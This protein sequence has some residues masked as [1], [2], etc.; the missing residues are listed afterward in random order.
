MKNRFKFAINF[1]AFS[2]FLGNPQY[3]EFLK[4]SSEDSEVINNDFINNNYYILGPGDELFIDFLDVLGIR[5]PRTLTVFYNK[6]HQVSR[7]S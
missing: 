2:L 4:A 3:N 6:A 7:N 1:L 5:K